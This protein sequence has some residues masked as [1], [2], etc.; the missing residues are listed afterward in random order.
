MEGVRFVLDIAQ[1]VEQCNKT[2]AMQACAS[3]F[4][5]VAEARMLSEEMS[6][7]FHNLVS[8]SRGSRLPWLCGMAPVWVWLFG[9]LQQ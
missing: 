9:V 7:S 6:I 8:V 5:A 2:T 1:L 3:S 4:A